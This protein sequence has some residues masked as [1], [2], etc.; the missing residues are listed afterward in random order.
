M[1]RRFSINFAIFSI[2]MDAFLTVIGLGLAKFV[3]PLLDRLPFVN[4]IGEQIN[5]PTSLYIIFPLLWVG[6]LSAFA[7]YDGRKYLRVVDEYAM[8]TLGSVIASISMAGILYLSYRQVSRLLFL[9]FVVIV[10]ILFL[11][12]RGIARL[13]FRLRKEWPD[14]PRQVLHRRR[15]PTGG[16]DRNTNPRRRESKTWNAGGTWTMKS[17]WMQPIPTFWGNSA[18]SASWSTSQPSRM[19]SSPCHIRFTKE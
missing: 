15:R 9:S 1:L 10:F 18:T 2:I 5:L 13:G 17:T 14:V 3:R 19:W 16:A 11:A 12:W 8:L 6:I 7:I 4:P